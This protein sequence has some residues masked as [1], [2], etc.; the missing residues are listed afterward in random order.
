MPIVYG[1]YIEDGSI[2]TTKL[3]SAVNDRLPSTTQMT[4]LGPLNVSGKLAVASD[5]VKLQAVTASGGTNGLMTPTDKLKLNTLMTV[6]KDGA[7]VGESSLPVTTLNF[8]GSAFSVSRGADSSMVITSS[9][10][11]GSVT[12]VT[13]G[14]G[15]KA[16]TG[17]TAADPVLALN[18]GDGVMTSAGLTTLRL[19]TGLIL[20]GASPTK[21]LAIDFCPAGT[22]SET[23]AVRGDDTRL[24]PDIPVQSIVA[25][26]AITVSAGGVGDVVVGLDTGYTASALRNGLMS[27][28]DYF[29]LA[30]APSP[31][32][33]ITGVTASSPLTGGGV[34]GAVAIGANMSILVR[35]DT[36]ADDASGSQHGLMSVAHYT[37]LEGITA[38]ASISGVTA[39][40]ALSGGGTGGAVTLNVLYGA[41]L[42]LS[43]L[44]LV[45]NFTSS[46]GEHG[47][48]TQVARGDHVHTSLYVA[49]A[50]AINTAAGSGLLGGGALSGD[51]SLE[52]NFVPAGGDAGSATTVARGDHVH[53]SLYSVLAHNHD[54][55]YPAIGHQIT[56]GTGLT[57][58]GALETNPTLAVSFGGTGAASSSARSDHNHDAAY[59]GVTHT[60]SSAGTG[61]DTLAP[62]VFTPNL[63]SDPVGP[64]TG[65]VWFNTGTDLLKY[66]DSGSTQIIASK[67]YVDG[68]ADVTS[69]IAGNGIDVSGATGDV[70]VSAEFCADGDYTTPN[71]IPLNTD[72][73]L[74]AVVGGAGTPGLMTGADKNRLDSILGT[75]D[76]GGLPV[77][78]TKSLKFTGSGVTGVA[79]DT[80]MVTVTIT[81]GTGGSTGVQT[82]G[83]GSAI[84]VDATDPDNP[85]VS[86]VAGNGINLTSSRVNVELGTGLELNGNA[87]RVDS[88]IATAASVTALDFFKDIARADG[89][90]EFSASGN[91][92][93][94]RFAASGNAA[95][96]FDALT[97]KVTVSA[98]S[99]VNS[100]A[101]DNAS[102]LVSSGTGAVTLAA[103][104]QSPL[105][106]D[107]SG[108][109]LGYD[110]DNFSDVAG[111][112]TLQMAGTGS[113]KTAAKSDHTHSY[114]ALTTNTFSG[115]QTL[116]GG[117]LVSTRL[118][119]PTAASTNPGDVYFTSDTLKV[120]T[121]TG[122]RTLGYGSVTSVTGGN[123]LTGTVTSSGSLAVLL[124]DS[125]GLVVDETG[126]TVDFGAGAAQV[127]SGTHT[128]TGVYSAFDHNHDLVYAPISHAHSQYADKTAANTF[129]NLQNFDVG[130]VVGTRLGIPTEAP[131]TLH[132][133]DL[134]FLD[135]ALKVYDGS[136]TK[137]FSGAISSVAAGNGLT[138]GG[139]SGALSLAVQPVASGPITVSP[140]GVG[141]DVFE[142]GLEIYEGKLALKWMPVG[143]RMNENR[144]TCVF[145]SD[146][147]E[148]PS[149]CTSAADARLK[150]ARTPKMTLKKG[151][152]PV[153][154]DAEV[155]VL[156]VV[157][158]SDLT[159]NAGEHTATLT[160]NAG[161]VTTVSSVLTGSATTPPTISFNGGISGA[162]ITVTQA[163]GAGTTA[164]VLVPAVYRVHA[165]DPAAGLSRPVLQFEGATVTAGE[166]A[167]TT[168]V[169]IV[170]TGS[171][172]V[173][174]DGS[175][176]GTGAEADPLGLN[177][178][179]EVLTD[180]NSWGTHIRPARSD[181]HHNGWYPQLAT[182]NV[183]P[184]VSSQSFG[185][186]STSTTPWGALHI[187]ANDAP[188]ADAAGTAIPVTTLSLGDRA[189]GGTTPSW[190]TAALI[191]DEAGARAKLDS[192]VELLTDIFQVGRRAT[193]G[194]ALT[195]WMRLVGDTAS[196]TWATSQYGKG[197][198]VLGYNLGASDKRA[199]RVHKNG[200]TFPG[201]QWDGSTGKW[202]ATHDGTNYCAV[203][204]PVAG[205][206]MTAT[207]GTGANLGKRTLNVSLGTGST[208]AAAGNHTHT[209]G[210]VTGL[211]AALAGKAASVHTHTTAQVTGLDTALAGKA[212]TAH[213]HTTSQVTGLNDTL[214]HKVNDSTQVIAGDGLT[215]GGDLSYSRTLAVGAG[216]GISVAAD[217]V[218]VQFSGTGSLNMAARGD[219]SHTIALERIIPGKVVSVSAG[220]LNYIQPYG[221][222]YW[223]T[224]KFDTFGSSFY[225]AQAQFPAMNVQD[226]SRA[227]SVEFRVSYFLA[228]AAATSVY[229]YTAYTI[230]P[231]SNGIWTSETIG[232]GSA[233]ISRVTGM[234]TRASRSSLVGTYQYS[235]LRLPYSAG[236]Q[237]SVKFWFW[238]PNTA[239]NSAVYI[240][241]VELATFESWVVG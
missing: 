18:A 2:G 131:G 52:A 75:F 13:P 172:T 84:S 50:R 192:A 74:K 70:T 114:A 176:K 20:T 199:F 29:K 228:G 85:V 27:S 78:T 79:G 225:T 159:W 106:I 83:A 30:A 129:A 76:A 200:G 64:A 213:T 150:N 190:D 33:T 193:A 24:Y 234:I 15:L 177:Y 23:Q 235:P 22:F 241:S 109:L 184:V 178:R 139:E 206:A 171:S 174:K 201:F 124:Q 157:G 77:A 218:S 26:T 53:D 59:S 17:S 46:G 9:A 217:A 182:S 89:T 144:L 168:K 51:L 71:Q 73:R 12:S 14:D 189:D 166:D 183:Y 169:T 81:A 196:G 45:P 156:N 211:D 208:Q 175:L 94:L 195:P 236:C 130:A 43:G 101:A 113:A 108:I 154:A 188:Y 231:V 126:L 158:A 111:A 19:G 37:K 57:G 165:G 222:V 185:F 170:A 48:G 31:I 210:Q 149:L 160:C 137:S 28:A 151:G 32:G 120:Y 66:K 202:T 36:T 3:A 122:A 121:S 230:S 134:W 62:V 224:T 163:G 229:L 155:Q 1:Q 16:G 54:L 162:G 68:L 232:D 104:V 207:E 4:A 138:G 148:D 227:S 6:L 194:G 44:D 203:V 61:G 209:T 55:V 82:V 142:Q 65:Q 118:G 187:K 91:D 10:G 152:T 233:A 145:A 95:V 47:T 221:G 25:G 105:A 99:D 67:A 226:F 7:V 136:L 128:H 237:T 119:V 5:D 56:A 220:T 240:T 60:H 86:V 205:T 21:S 93:K 239:G 135:G 58:G 125:S 72:T 167:N 141:L 115:L 127:A 173:S 214:S 103:Q 8:T 238:S 116:S 38:G 140:S 69:I 215:G 96:A 143:L 153:Q 216:A 42:T 102:L 88:T 80:D 147:E 98:T 34:S 223:E 40:T 90:T 107:G 117:A 197:D 132:A 49:A 35:K 100:V 87:V 39:G 41:G 204:E 179:N 133:G 191:A 123:G 186:A 63:G 97:N 92:S 161:S 110:T 112:L 198:L 11:G 180:G 146:I 181:H 219:H 164:T 212:P